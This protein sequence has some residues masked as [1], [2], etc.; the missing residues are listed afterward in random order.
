MGKLAFLNVL[1]PSAIDSDGY[2]IFRLTRN[3]TG[4]T[5]DTIT[6]VDHKTKI[7]KFLL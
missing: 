2:I 5:T 6:V 4:V 7:Q 3:R 1:D